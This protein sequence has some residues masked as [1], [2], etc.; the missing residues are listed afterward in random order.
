[1]S[2]ASV[3][4]Y[5]AFR[6]FAH[7]VEIHLSVMDLIRD[8]ED[9]RMLTYEVARELARQQVR[10]A[11]L[12]VTPYSHV[13]RG[14]PAPEVCAA[15]EDARAAATRASWITWWSTGSRWRCARP[16]TCAPAP[17]RRSMRIRCRG[18]SRPAWPRWPARP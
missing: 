9:V 11:E 10:Y 17:S 12:T 1:M 6:D 2:L 4:D 14:I 3:P 16:R 7:F 13:S 15:T 18:W 8:D 5:F